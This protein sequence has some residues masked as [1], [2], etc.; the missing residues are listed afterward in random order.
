[1]KQKLFVLLLALA[2]SL[3]GLT[4]CGAGGEDRDEREGDDPGL[5]VP[6]DDDRDD[7]ENDD[8]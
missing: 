2:L 7:D 5:V 3:G 8:E 6:G 4:A 1:M